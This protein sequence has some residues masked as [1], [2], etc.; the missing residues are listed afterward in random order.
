[1]CEITCIYPTWVIWVFQSSQLYRMS[2]FGCIQLH[3]Y[4]MLPALR[5]VVFFMLSNN[6]CCLAVFE[7][8]TCGMSNILLR[9]SSNLFK[10]YTVYPNDP[11]T[12]AWTFCSA[13]KLSP[14]SVW[15]FSCSIIIET[16]SIYRRT[17]L[18]VWFKYCV[19]PF[20]SKIAKL[21]I[22]FVAREARKTS[23]E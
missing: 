12:C 7:K 16:L 21:L 14:C 1:M 3:M 20:A 6:T 11:S 10:I 2:V 23:D 22:T 9:S 17:G 4:D 15:I 8:G 19:L 5:V 13:S 18:I